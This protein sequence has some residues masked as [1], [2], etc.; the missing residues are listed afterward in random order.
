MDLSL[1]QRLL[2]MLRREEDG[3]A[4]SWSEPEE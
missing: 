4:R 2:Q 1:E 3:E